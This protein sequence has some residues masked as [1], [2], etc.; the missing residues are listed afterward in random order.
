M[1]L[2]FLIMSIYMLAFLSTIFAIKNYKI[3]WACKSEM[4]LY[5]KLSV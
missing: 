4:Q 3:K 1:M 5:E 2:I